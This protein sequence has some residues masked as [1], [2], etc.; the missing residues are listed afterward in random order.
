MAREQETLLASRKLKVWLTNLSSRLK[1]LN[2]WENKGE[3][4]RDG[5]VRKDKVQEERKE[6]RGQGWGVGL[7]CSKKHQ[8]GEE[9]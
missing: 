2:S 5:K 3:N 9:D 6:K 4:Q 7:Q 1:E 8:N